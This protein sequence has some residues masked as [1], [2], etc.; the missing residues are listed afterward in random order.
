MLT[1]QIGD[2]KKKPTTAD[3]KKFFRAMINNEMVTAD[4]LDFWREKGVLGPNATDIV[5]FLICC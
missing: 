1:D 3:Q 4:R 2:K 5:V